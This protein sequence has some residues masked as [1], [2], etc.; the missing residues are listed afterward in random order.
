MAYVLLLEVIQH[1]TRNLEK[2]KD[3]FKK[4]KAFYF[5]NFLQNLQ[6]CCYICCSKNKSR[7]VLMN[8]VSDIFLSKLVCLQL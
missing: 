1:A 3:F 4:M 6:Q 2:C 8:E 5:A 7:G